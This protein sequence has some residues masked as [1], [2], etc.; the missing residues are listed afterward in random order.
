M[1]YMMFYMRVHLGRF[2]FRLPLRKSVQ[3][4]HMVAER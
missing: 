3:N 4:I 2:G 1:F